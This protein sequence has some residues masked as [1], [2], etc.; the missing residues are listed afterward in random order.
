MIRRPPRS[1][2][3]PNPPLFRPR[4]HEPVAALEDVVDEAEAVGLV[5]LPWIV[6]EQAEEDPRREQRVDPRVALHAGCT[7][8]FLSSPSS[9]SASVSFSRSF[10][11]QDSSAARLRRRMPSAFSYA[12]STIVRTATS[13]SRA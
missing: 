6:A 11:A 13:I 8:A 2:L 9:A 1:P 5:R 10:C 3:F 4:R 12:P 7:T